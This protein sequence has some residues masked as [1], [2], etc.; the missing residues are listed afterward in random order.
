MKTKQKG[1]NKLEGPVTDIPIE[2]PER[3][4]YVKCPGCRRII[5]LEQL[6]ASHDVCPRCGHHMRL[7]A[8]RRIELTCDEGSFREWDADLAATDF[9]NFPHYTEKLAAARETSGE[10]DASKMIESV[11]G[12]TWSGSRCWGFSGEV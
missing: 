12:S 4:A 8:R 7:S 11:G 3:R 5:D 10:V 6:E 2:L 9:L 1:I